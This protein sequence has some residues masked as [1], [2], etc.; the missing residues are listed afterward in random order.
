MMYRNSIRLFIT[1][2]MVV[3]FVS[4]C[5]PAPQ[6]SSDKLNVVATTTLVGDA[7]RIV[8]GD[9]ITLTVL[10]PAG[11]DEHSY[12]LSAQDMVKVSSADILLINGAGLEPYAERLIDNTGDQTRSISVSDGIPL[13]SGPPHADEHADE[14]DD[15][16]GEGDPHVWTDPNNVIIWVDNIENRFSEADPANAAGYQERAA[17]YR[18]QLVELDGWI[19]EQ[20]QQVAPERRKLV[21][22]H[23]VFNY[24]ANRYGFEQVGTVVRGFSTLASPSA[25]DIAA[26]E[27][28]IRELG[29]PVIFTGSNF[30][31]SLAERIAQD[32]QTRLVQVQTGSL[33]GP[34]GPAPTYLDYMRFNV[35]AIVEALK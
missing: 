9:D 32:T 7:A 27:D 13:L 17:E 10:I 18:T 21:T 20:V 15:A 24:F 28:S 34:D 30:N 3:V 31:P 19:Q 23:T 8:G 14:D 6:V 1:A 26:L 11:V 4:A 35:N 12:E 22:D 25:Q 29:V 33:S 2:M 16:H 5:S